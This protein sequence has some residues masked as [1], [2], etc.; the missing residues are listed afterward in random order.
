MCEYSVFVCIHFTTKSR[1]GL[2]LYHVRVYF[3]TCVSAAFAN[4]NACMESATFCLTSAAAAAAIAA[5]VALAAAD[6]AAASAVV[7][8]AN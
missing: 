8:A 3:V 2:V 7:F 6:I 4:A 5:A 1:Q